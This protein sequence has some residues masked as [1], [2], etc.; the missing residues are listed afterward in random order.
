MMMEA[1][2][3]QSCRWASRLDTQ[4]GPK[5]LFEPEGHLLENSVLL[6]G[7]LVFLF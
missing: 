7:G 5:P 3:S 4:K 2:K 6:E 1:E